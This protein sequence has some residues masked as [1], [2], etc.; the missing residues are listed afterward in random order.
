VA[1]VIPVGLEDAR[2]TNFELVCFYA[3]VGKFLI[4][5]AVMFLT[6]PSLIKRGATT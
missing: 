2:A 6:E 3:L 5:T 1:L 4:V